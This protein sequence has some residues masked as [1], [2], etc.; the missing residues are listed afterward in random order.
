MHF[1][2]LSL[3]THGK[4]CE[5]LDDI[6]YTYG[7]KQF[8]PDAVFPTVSKGAGMQ[9]SQILSH[10]QSDPIPLPSP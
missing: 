4:C 3:V 5:T 6:L 8:D 9:S 1:Y 7:Q 2:P 10:L